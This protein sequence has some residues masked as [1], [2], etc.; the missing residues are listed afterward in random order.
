MR[1]QNPRYDSRPLWNDAI[2][3]E[4]ERLAELCDEHSNIVARRI[5]QIAAARLEDFEDDFWKKEPNAVPFSDGDV[6]K[7]KWTKLYRIFQEELGEG[8]G[9][10]IDALPSNRV[11]LLEVLQLITKLDARQSNQTDKTYRPSETLRNGAESM[12]TLKKS[13]RSH[14]IKGTRE[15]SQEPET[16]VLGKINRAC[17]RHLSVEPLGGLT[18]ESVSCPSRFSLPDSNVISS[19]GTSHRHDSMTFA[20]TLQIALNPIREEPGDGDDSGYDESTNDPLANSISVGTSEGDGSAIRSCVTNAEQIHS[21][22]RPNIQRLQE[23]RASRRG[24]R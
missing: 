17:L 19:L 15:E 16:S 4:L 18:M 14:S 20:S 6:D 3:E 13:W 21:P 9:R 10:S 11:G 24:S 7:N 1:L 2:I 8:G 5:R 12:L 23:R 22:I